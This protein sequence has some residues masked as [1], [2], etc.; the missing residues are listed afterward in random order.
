M[1]ALP[2]WG[3]PP[4]SDP[5]V[6]PTPPPTHSLLNL[7]LQLKMGLMV[8]PY[9]SQGCQEEKVERK[10]LGHPEW[11]REAGNTLCELSLLR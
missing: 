11:S 6:T 9:F 7:S 2:P 10:T 3:L 4:G 1:S 8:S 5:A